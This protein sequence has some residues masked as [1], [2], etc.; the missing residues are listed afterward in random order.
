MILWEAR[1]EQWLDPSLST[2]RNVST[3]NARTVAS[4]IFSLIKISLILCCIWV[5][6]FRLKPAKQ[7]SCMLWPHHFVTRD[8]GNQ[9]LIYKPETGDKTHARKGGRKGVELLSRRNRINSA[10]GNSPLFRVEYFDVGMRWEVCFFTFC[11]TYS[12]FGIVYHSTSLKQS[13]RLSQI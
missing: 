10:P 3:V 2:L 8:R 6:L 12:T 13:A 4:L 7:L 11:E 1:L 5:D 9:R